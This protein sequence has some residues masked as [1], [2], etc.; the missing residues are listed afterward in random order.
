MTVG[1]ELRDDLLD[2][3]QPV[4][5]VQ[6]LRREIAK[7]TAVVTAARRNDARRREKAVARQQV[8]P[9]CRIVAIR[10]AIVTAID[11]LQSA[12]L[13]VLENLRPDLYTLAERDGIRVRGGL[14]GRSQHMQSAEN[15]LRA[16]LPI[17]MRELVRPLGEREM[18]GDSDDFRKRLEGRR[19]LEQILVP[20]AD[21]PMSGRRGCRGRE[22][23]RRRQ[24]VL[25]E[26]GVRILAIE[27]VD[28]QRIAPA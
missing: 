6:P 23:E 15:D 4:R 25:A 12:G 28:Q 3:A 11:R 14:R 18:H 7:P 1:R 20:V 26:A 9:R 16:P 19:T 8:A 2:V 27:R 13:D 10:P 17:P 22:R 24:H 21:L 5:H